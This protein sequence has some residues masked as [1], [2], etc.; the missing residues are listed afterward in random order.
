MTQLERNKSIL[1]KY[2]PAPAVDLI[3]V[4]IVTYDFKLKIKRS[5][6]TKFGDYRPPKKD[7]NHQIT[8][9]NDLNPY[10]FLITLVHEIAHL[11][12]FNKH[13]NRVMPHG[14]EWKEEYKELMRHFMSEH[15]F[16]ADVITALQ[17]Y[18]R[19]PAASSCSDATLIRVL[20][21][22]DVRKDT[23]LLEQL[24][25][26]ALF[27]TSDGREFIK[28]QRLRKRFRCLEKGTSRVYLFNPF[29]EVKSL[30]EAV[31]N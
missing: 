5:R 9:N 12:N 24:P 11:S 6:S 20:K 10:A 23:Q 19:N 21:R 27:T 29:C 8:I 7:A 31:V 17:S 14:D 13:R 25:E 15:I 22:Y 1:H 18:M 3:A 2:I 16:P 28:G 30:A 4:W 26:Q